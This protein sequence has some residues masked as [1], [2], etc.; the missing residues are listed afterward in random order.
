MSIFRAHEVEFGGYPLIPLGKSF[1]VVNFVQLI[2][3]KK[4]ISEAE[5]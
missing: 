3:K 5:K 2:K 4:K 1:T